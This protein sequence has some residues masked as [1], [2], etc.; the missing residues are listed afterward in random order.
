MRRLRS[1]KQDRAWIQVQW[2][3][4]ALK[5]P[6]RV[7]VYGKKSRV[8]FALFSRPYLHLDSPFSAWRSS[9]FHNEFN[10]D[11]KQRSFFQLFLLHDRMY[12]STIYGS[13]AWLASFLKKHTNG[14]TNCFIAARENVFLCLSENPSC[15]GTSLPHEYSVSAFFRQSCLLCICCLVRRSIRVVIYHRY[16][17]VF[18][19]I[20]KCIVND[21][22]TCLQS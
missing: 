3:R 15:T 17:L 8:P 16:C 18:L 20:V 6:V 21:T 13:F 1:K 11:S 5:S 9:W 19:K 10:L 4:R 22:Y 12:V 7:R 2:M 14:F